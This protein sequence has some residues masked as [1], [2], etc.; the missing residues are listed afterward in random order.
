M[1]APHNEDKVNGGQIIH[2]ESI[3]IDE[4]KEQTNSLLNP[5]TEVQRPLCAIDT[6]E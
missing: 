6:G 5:V 4:L 3:A 2:Y 1:P